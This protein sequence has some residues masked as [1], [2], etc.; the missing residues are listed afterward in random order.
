MNT[1]AEFYQRLT[2]HDGNPFLG[3]RLK[4]KRAERHL[5]ELANAARQLPM[6]RGYRF[7]LAPRIETGQVEIV[8]QPTPMPLEFAAVI[9]DATHNI[10]SAFEFAAVALTIP[11]IGRGKPEDAYFPTGKDQG[12]FELALT[13]KMK[14]APSTA[15]RLVEELEPYPGGKYGLRALH[16]LDNL[17]KHKLLI[18]S[19]A[20][21]RIDTL[22]AFYRDEPRSLSSADFHA[23]DDGG[24]FVAFIDCPG[25]ASIDEFRIEGQ[26][27]ASLS[28][29][30]RKG[31]PFEGQPIA[32]ALLGLVD[33]AKAFV[34][35]CE[36]LH[37]IATKAA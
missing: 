30:F 23:M 33:V 36:N 19:V 15:L 35:K 16:E 11:P 7:L 10:R 26:F 2:Y 20:H 22:E 28:I 1:P 24:R 3:A 12:E 13:R 4:I 18:P 14:G 29:T 21:L 32:P 6:K 37:T 17:D 34:E 9:G 25:I 27:K 31:Q 5:R 8:Y